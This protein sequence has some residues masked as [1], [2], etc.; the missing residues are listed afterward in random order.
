MQ[1]NTRKNNGPSP[2]AI[3]QRIAAVCAKKGGRQRSCWQTLGGCASRW[4]GIVQTVR[5]TRQLGKKHSIASWARSEAFK[6][7]TVATQWESSAAAD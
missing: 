7:N 3:S 5:F 4:F 6:I 2:S 1:E